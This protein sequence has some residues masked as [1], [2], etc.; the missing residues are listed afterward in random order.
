MRKRTWKKTMAVLLTT[1]LSVAVLAGCGGNGTQPSS[2]A[3]EI[4]STVGNENTGENADSEGAGNQ[5]TVQEAVGVVIGPEGGAT[6]SDV[7]TEGLEN[8]TSSKD[9]LVMRMDSDPGTLDNLTTSIM[10]GT[11]ILS[12]ANC[13]LMRS[14]YDENMGT[15]YEVGTRYSIAT[16]YEMA[17]DYSSLTWTIRDDATWSDGNPVTVEDILFSI[18]RYQENSRYDY[19]DYTKLEKIDDTHLSVGFTKKDANAITGI[20]AMTLVEKAVFESL[21]AEKY[22][23][24]PSFVGCGAYKITDWV[25]GDSM[26]LEAVDG[27]FGGDPKI[28][29]I[30]IRFIAEASVAMMELETG[31]IDIIDIPNWTDVSNVLKGNYEG[32]A[33]HIQIPDMLHTMV[34]YNLSA[35]SPCQDLLVRQAIAYAIDRDTV[36][37]GAYEGVGETAYTFFSSNVENMKVF[38]QETWPYHH[39]VEKAKELLVEAG[40]PNGFEMTILTNQDANRSMAAQIIKSQL[41]EVGINA[42]IVNYDNATYASTMSGE[43]DTWDIWLRN[44]T[45]T[46]VCWYQYFTNIVD[47][48]CHPNNDDETWQKYLSYA[49]SMAEEMD[50]EA[51]YA[52]ED[53]VQETIMNDALYTYNLISPVKHIIISDG[54]CNM[55]RMSYNWNML[56]AY[57]R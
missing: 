43:T 10:N 37:L 47:V 16:D 11:Q 50:A 44:W 51:R 45:T 33:K 5:S 49:S 17:K 34:G 8:I 18:S 12:M 7:T 20:G 14:S 28:K 24:T 22:F 27:Y 30:L 26:T 38:T 23:T 1:C 40:Y 25:A 29:K 41:A 53:K 56:D 4:A 19:I 42:N 31:G 15:V 13:A 32:V 57:F 52:I 3:E 46:G 39:D 2:A 9:T 55:E 21:G 35:D 48:N 6:T 36:A 54:L